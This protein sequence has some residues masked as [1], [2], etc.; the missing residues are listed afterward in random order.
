MAVS[1][2]ATNRARQRA[3]DCD[4]VSPKI[5]DELVREN[6]LR[7]TPVFT[8]VY[9]LIGF[10]ASMEHVPIYVF[11]FLFQSLQ[12]ALRMPAVRPAAARTVAVI[13]F[14]RCG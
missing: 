1:F 4:A 12:P 9:D 3:P 13:S 11:L 6:P 5:V 7:G 8:S 2:I 10:T 14:W